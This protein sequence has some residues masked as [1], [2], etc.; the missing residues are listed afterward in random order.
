MKH[1][2]MAHTSLLVG[3]AVA[4]ALVRYATLLGRIGSADSVIIRS[5]GVTGEVVE[6]SFL[7]NSGTVLIAEST[8][9][10]LQEPDNA[11]ALQYM[12]DQIARQET[13]ELP[14]LAPIEG[15]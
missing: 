15:A 13:Y 9:S 2:T 14:L 10:G 4:N 12:Q 5:I 7:L 11:E 8:T 6:A 3:D 1:V